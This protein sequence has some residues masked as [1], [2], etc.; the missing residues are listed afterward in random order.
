MKVIDLHCDTILRLSEKRDENIF[1]S[2]GHINYEKLV[3]GDVLCQCFALFTKMHEL[4]DDSYSPFERLTKL[5]EI[6]LNE[7]NN[8]NGK[9][10]R[11]NNSKDIVDNKEGIS[12]MLTIEG[13]D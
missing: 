7:I 13:V 11:V 3:K 10:K 1:T 5:Y 4:V 2:S 8:S 6:F 9:L 12:A